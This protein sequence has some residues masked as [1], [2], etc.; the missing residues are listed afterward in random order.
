M[1]K[2]VLMMLAVIC[3]CLL[4]GC[5]DLGHDKGRTGDFYDYYTMEKMADGSYK[6]SAEAHMAKVLPLIYFNADQETALNLHFDEF[7]WTLNIQL[8]YVYENEQGVQERLILEH[9]AESDTLSA[10][11]DIE[12]DLA[13]G[14]SRLEWRTANKG[15]GILFELLLSNKDGV[16]ISMRSPS[17]EEFNELPELAS[18]EELQN[19]LNFSGVP[20]SSSMSFHN[21]EKKLTAGVPNLLLNCVVQQACQMPLKA[22]L[23]NVSGDVQLVYVQQNGKVQQLWDSRE[24]NGAEQPQ[25]WQSPWEYVLPEKVDGAEVLT[26]DLTLDLLPDVGRLE[27]RTENGAEFRL[28]L[29]LEDLSSLDSNYVGV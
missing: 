20:G 12:L 29:L 2:V 9:Q 3:C 25:S 22:A 28:N 8:V 5:A 11:L 6:V 16:D 23:W 24:Q 21:I 26:I 19:G 10:N 4:T 15:E 13:A 7:S 1:K 27:W 18:L 17:D 14:E